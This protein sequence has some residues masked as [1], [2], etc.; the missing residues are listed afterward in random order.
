M[1]GF[2]DGFTK[3]LSIAL[4]YGV[5]LDKLIRSFVHI[6]FD[7]S[8]MTKNPKIRF[9][10]S[11]YDYLSKYLDVKYFGGE[12]TGLNKRTSDVPEVVIENKWS[13]SVRPPSM[14]SDAPPCNNCGAI[15]RRAGSCHICDVCG[16]SSSCS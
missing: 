7:P 1:N 16:S 2:I 13:M 5:P 14:S 11:L 4:Q 8:G 9:T 12:I 10:D 15:T 3:L 6:K